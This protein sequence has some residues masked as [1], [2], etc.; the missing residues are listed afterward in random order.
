MVHFVFLLSL[1]ATAL[2]CAPAAPGG[3]G[4][5]APGGSPPAPP[6]G[7]SPPAG[8]WWWFST[9]WWWLYSQWSPKAFR[10]KGST[11]DG[12]QGKLRHGNEP[13]L[14][15]GVQIGSEFP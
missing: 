13:N 3:G 12:Q 4:A 11:H 2:A 7:G 15:G 9:R 5:P 1:A 14:P 6:S 10:R 8:W